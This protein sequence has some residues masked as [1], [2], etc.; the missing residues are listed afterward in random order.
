M[1]T[2]RKIAVL[3]LILLAF[4]GSFYAQANKDSLLLVIKESGEDTNK[5]KALNKLAWA[6]RSE[7]PDQAMKYALEA[8]D[9]SQKIGYE[10]GEADS[11]SHTGVFYYRKGLY[12]QATEF[13]LKALRI[14]ERIGDDEGLSISY[15]NLGNLYSEQ[16]NNDLAIGYYEKAAQI[17]SESLENKSRLPIVYMNLGT[18]YI[19]QGKYEMGL[20]FCQQAKELAKQQ[21]NYSI[22]A[23]A[24]NNIG[25]VYQYQDKYPEALKI[26]TE[27]YQL[28]ESSGDKFGMIDAAINIGN[29]YR[30]Q[31]QYNLTYEWHNRA[32]ELSKEND[33]AEGLRVVY[34]SLAQDYAAV[35][36]Y[37][38][39]Y[40]YQLQFKAISD[41]L[42]NIE[43]TARIAEVN[44]RYEQERLANELKIKEQELDL[45]QKSITG[46]R[47]LFWAAIGVVLLI[48][49]FTAI[50]LRFWVQNRS[51]RKAIES[52]NP[53]RQFNR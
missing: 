47:F 20:K 18:I 5:V 43:N 46:N 48:L 30:H 9:L 35:G 50:C 39:A 41:S 6:L 10:K 22:E 37:E 23:N 44:M 7:N 26:F 16:R 8:G 25:V 3:I 14:R 51:L 1:I 53:F 33:Y 15:I 27:S 4:S 29:N 17:I 12:A 36:N 40:Q 13:H 21:G 28:N 19:S 52:T 32:L 38:K 2:N 42:F 11:Y 34:E 45:K 24:L 31:Q 49:S